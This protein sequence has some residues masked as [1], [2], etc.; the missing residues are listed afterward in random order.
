MNALLQTLLSGVVGFVDGVAA[1]WAQQRFVW[2]PQK[3]TEL[4][5]KVFDDAMTALAMYE[6]DALDAKLQGGKQA[7]YS[8]T[9]YIPHIACRRETWIALQKSLL[10]V[11]SFFSEE[12]FAAYSLATRADIQLSNIPHNNGFADKSGH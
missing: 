10:Q 4:R 12:A 2:R 11:K 3:R 6:S 7:E 8:G 9:G 5:N 1:L